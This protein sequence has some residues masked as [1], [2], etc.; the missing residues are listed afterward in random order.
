M[1]FK[2]NAQ[3]DIRDDLPVHDNER[4]AIEKL[5][6]VV[7]RSTGTQYHR[8]FNVVKFDAEG[9]A[10]AECSSHRFRSM[11]QVND[12]LVDAVTGKVFGDITD[13]WLA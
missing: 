9:A 7:E 3:I 10:I 4:L 1:S 5:A 12:D 13:E 2:R 6:R 8:F 11:M